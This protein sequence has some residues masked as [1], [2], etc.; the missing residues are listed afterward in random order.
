LLGEL[1]AFATVVALSPFSVIPAIALVVHSARPKPT[2]V[3]FVAGW[4]TGKAAITTLFVQAPRL[5]DGLDRPAPH[6]RS[7]VRIGAG[8]LF[9]AAGI[10]Y[11]RK[12]QRTVDAPQ[13]VSRIN[14]I[15]PA[16]A[17]AVGVALT[18]VNFKVLFM[19][20]AAG[21]AIGAAQLSVLGASV[22]VVYFTALAGSTAA[23]P[24]LAYTVWTHQVDRQLERFKVWMQRR[25]ALITAVLLVLI[26]VV[27]V[28]NGIR[29]I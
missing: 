16:G 13:W 27:L 22:A 12:P 19:C 15:T 18:V 3:A 23:L 25:Q 2:G 5:L 4:L 26:G 29:A 20:A 17:A 11:W 28:Y 6:W 1:T 21:F 8:I 9:I 7:W 14:S 24:I 10:W